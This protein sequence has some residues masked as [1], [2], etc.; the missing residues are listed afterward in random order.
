M[1]QKILWEME[2]LLVQGFVWERVKMSKSSYANDND[3]KKE[4]TKAITIPRVF[5]ENSQ[6]KNSV[7]KEEYTGNQKFSFSHIFFYSSQVSFSS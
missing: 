2:K 3:A 1:E 5:S 7:G 4:D 6:A